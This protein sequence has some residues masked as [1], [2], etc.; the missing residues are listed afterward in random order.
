MLPLVPVL[1]VTIPEIYPGPAIMTFDTIF[2]HFQE[3]G[4]WFVLRLIPSR[5]KRLLTH[6]T[7]GQELRLSAN[8]QEY[9]VTR[10]IAMRLFAIWTVDD[11]VAALPAAIRSIR[12]EGIA[13]VARRGQW[14]FF[15]QSC[16]RVFNMISMSTDLIPHELAVISLRPQAHTSQ[17]GVSVKEVHDAHLDTLLMVVALV[18]RQH[19]Y[20]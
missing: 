7:F 14:P 4:V 6:D 11:T 3:P 12:G 20:P 19:I 9:C 17:R 15:V 13:S 8:I 1:E 2:A 18:D 5:R 10:S 16:M